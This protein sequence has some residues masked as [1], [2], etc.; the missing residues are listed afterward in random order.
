[1]AD[2]PPDR[3][4]FAGVSYTRNN[5]RFAPLVD[6][7]RLVVL[8]TTPVPG[9]GG[10]R[11]F[12]LLFP[13]ETLFQEFVV[14]LV[15]RH[16]GVLGLAEA[17]V[18]S[19][20]RGASEWLVFED[21]DRGRFLLRPDL[22]IRDGS[23]T[24]TIV[25]TKW[26]RLK[27]R[28]EDARHGVVQADM[29]QLFAYAHRFDCA[30]N[31]LL[32]PAV[33]SKV[34]TRYHVRLPGVPVAVIRVETLDV[35]RDLM[36]ERTAVL[37]ELGGVLR[38]DPPRCRCRDARSSRT[39]AGFGTRTSVINSAVGTPRRRWRSIVWS[40]T[41]SWRG[42]TR[43]GYRWP[44]LSTNHTTGHFTGRCSTTI[45]HIRPGTTG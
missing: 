5:E 13:M 24:R 32:Y 12:S 45:Y 9:G 22:Q 15:R 18:I 25:D 35:G 29:Y 11:S 28:A 7:C 17:D 38:D 21:G 6:F 37:A 44:Q 31:V 34:R 14:G 20:A 30:D 16:A 27:P 40:S 8:G 39:F 4:A 2:Q 26:K 23:C 3:E 1:M 33:G 43:R 19:Q 10:V 41:T 42:Q 36:A